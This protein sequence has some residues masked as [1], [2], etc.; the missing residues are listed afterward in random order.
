MTTDIYSDAER[1]NTQLDDAVRP[2]RQSTAVSLHVKASPL[3][4]HAASDPLPQANSFT[5]FGTS[6]ARTTTNSARTFANSSGVKQYKVTLYTVAAIV[7]L[8]LIIKIGA[9]HWGRVQ[10]ETP[11]A[12]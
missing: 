8:W 1:Q 12:L 2:L 4:D 5:A 3:T 7:G 9:S 11:G 10:P 6:F